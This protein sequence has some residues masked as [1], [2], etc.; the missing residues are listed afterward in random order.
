M[1]NASARCGAIWRA[2]SGLRDVRFINASMSLSRYMLIV[3]AAPAARVPPNTVAAINQPDGHPRAASIIVG[4]V[5]TT[6]STMI[7]GFVS[8]MYAR[9]VFA[10]PTL[11]GTASS[12]RAAG[13]STGRC[14]PRATEYAATSEAHSKLE[15][16]T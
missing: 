12:A 4:T 14:R 16:T 5:V 10:R 6:S 8:A 15:S 7:R 2:G 13:A 3:L 1:P 11:C 9:M